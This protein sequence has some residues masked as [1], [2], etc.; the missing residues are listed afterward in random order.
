MD[1]FIAHLLS[2]RAVTVIDVR[3]L[4]S[5]ISNL[6]FVQGDMT[7]LPYSDNS[8]ESLSSLHV[9]EHVGLGRY[10]DQ[11]DPRGHL[12]AIS[13]LQRVSRPG[14][15][16]Y[17][18]VPIG[19][20]EHLEFDGHRIFAVQTILKAFN[21]MKL[22]SFS[23]IDDQGDLHEFKN[24]SEVPDLRYGCGLFELSKN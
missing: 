7:Q 19:T 22:I 16:L 15:R 18:S 14:G 6:D 20:K 12:Q 11:V 3:P 8:I 21:Q 17:F 2:F 9:V 10:G 23:Y 24:P 1:G 13:E 4:Y 5:T